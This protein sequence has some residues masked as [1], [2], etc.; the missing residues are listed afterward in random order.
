VSK[1]D[2]FNEVN[3]TSKSIYLSVLELKESKKRNYCEVIELVMRIFWSK[4]VTA[5]V[6]RYEGTASELASLSQLVGL[7]AE[8]DG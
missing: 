5:D 4:I 3:L 1:K 7:A 2:F 8:S 6:K